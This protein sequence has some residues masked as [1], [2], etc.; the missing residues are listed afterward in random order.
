MGSKSLS[1]YKGLKHSVQVYK[2]PEDNGGTYRSG[3]YL[4]QI[5]QKLLISLYK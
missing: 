3:T 4:G 2:E 1:T 5:P